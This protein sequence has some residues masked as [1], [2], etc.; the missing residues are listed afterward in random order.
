M[1]VVLCS[2]TSH[3]C[4][5]M[6]AQQQAASY[7][8]L[9]CCAP[10]RHG[11]ERPIAVGVLQ[12]LRGVRDEI[13]NNIHATYKETDLFKVFQTG[14]WLVVGVCAHRLGMQ[15][16]HGMSTAQPVAMLRTMST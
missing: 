11:A 13:I 15:T 9:W 5:G 4:A 2:M 10:S 14:V 7:V 8:W 1:F 6:S 12:L 3:G 16:R